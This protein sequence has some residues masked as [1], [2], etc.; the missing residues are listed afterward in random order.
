MQSIHKISQNVNIDEIF[1]F[2]LIVLKE[3]IEL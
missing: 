3:D 2:I 1:I